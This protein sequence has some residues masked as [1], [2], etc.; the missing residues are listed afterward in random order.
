MIEI[1]RSYT[2]EGKKLYYGKLKFAKLGKL[3]VWFTYSSK[4]PI[5]NGNVKLEGLLAI[6]SN[7]K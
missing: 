7:F 1:P 4:K 2:L 3:E 5:M 6:R